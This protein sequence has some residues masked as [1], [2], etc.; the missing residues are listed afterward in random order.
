MTGEAEVMPGPPRQSL[1]HC[2][3]LLPSLC[4]TQ[5]HSSLLLLLGLG[6]LGLLGLLK[7]L[8][9]FFIGRKLLVGG[10]DCLRRGHSNSNLQLSIR[11]ALH[12]AHGRGH[13][14]IIA[15][16]GGANVLFAGKSIDGGIETYPANV[17]EKRFHPS[18]G[19]TVRR[20]MRGFTAVVKVA[21][22]IATR[23]SGVSHE[24]N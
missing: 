20:R 2:R 1:A 15:S 7:E 21:A 17:R 12:H 19:G 16:D 18:V 9:P 4:T 6:Q 24:G 10:K 14:G 22:D 5:S 8:G 13:V 23:N 3:P 11:F